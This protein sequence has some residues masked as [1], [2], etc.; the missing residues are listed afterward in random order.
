[1]ANAVN[2]LSEK[3]YQK[4]KEVVSKLEQ[5]LNHHTLSQLNPGQDESL[6][7]FY[8][9]YLADMRHLIV[10]SE[11]V[12]E[13][14]GL[15][16]RR[17]QFSEEATEKALFEAYHQCVN[18]FYYPKHECYSEDGRYAYTGQDSIRFRK[19]PVRALREVTVELSKVFEV[20][21]EELAFYESDYATQ[22]RM[23][24]EKVSH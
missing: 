23:Q 21:R 14:I 17:P 1:M 15:Q 3:T 12:Y 20:M 22:R 9:G 6:Q 16:L 2:A 4:L 13:K 18:G 19:M 24:G 5:F 10:Q 11:V 8:R 7:E